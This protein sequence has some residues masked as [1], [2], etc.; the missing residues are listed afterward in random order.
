MSIDYIIDVYGLESNDIIP[1]NHKVGLK[2]AINKLIASFDE[3]SK[4]AKSYDELY[5][6]IEACYPELI[7][8]GTEY[9]E[10]ELIEDEADLGTIGEIAASH[11]GFL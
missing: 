1:E 2:D 6:K 10:D 3:I 4:K 7:E 11:F 8:D 9:D 5:H